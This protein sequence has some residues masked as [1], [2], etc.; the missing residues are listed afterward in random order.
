M[1]AT[2]R[3]H[4]WAPDSIVATYAKAFEEHRS[5][6]L[7]TKSLRSSSRILQE[8]YERYQKISR[9]KKSDGCQR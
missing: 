9:A 1:R 6:L 4:D 7:A 8:N 5:L 2:E 3:G